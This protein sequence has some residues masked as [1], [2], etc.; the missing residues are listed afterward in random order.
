MK[1]AISAILARAGY[2]L[3]KLQPSLRTTGLPEWDADIRRIRP[4]TMVSHDA[5]VCLYRQVLHCEAHGI[6]G[7]FVECGVWKGGA[8]GLMALANMKYGSQRRT[9]HLFDSFQDIC[10]PDEAIDGP[11]AIREARSW[12][13]GGALG[14]L[15]PLLGFYDHKGGPGTVDGN[16]DLLERQLE[17]DP[18]HVSYHVGWFQ[19]TLP[20]DAPRLGPIALLRLDADWYAS[21][22]VCLDHLYDNVVS[23]GFVVIDDYGAYEGCRAAVDEF[24]RVRGIRAFLNAVDADCVYWIKQ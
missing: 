3:S 18:H 17:Y 7:A 10:E 16:R 13:N 5:L 11:R 12:A 2:R 23:G 6:P 24:M 19:D 1:N 9:I 20:H 4:Y 22:R 21:T 15:V 8:V 14:R